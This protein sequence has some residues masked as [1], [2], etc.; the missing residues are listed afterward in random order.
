[1]L[2]LEDRLHTV[3]QEA[4]YCKRSGSQV[5]FAPTII[6][7]LEDLQGMKMQNVRVDAVV[8]DLLV[9]G[10]FDLSALGSPVKTNQ[11]A[12]AG[13]VMLD[14]LSKDY[15]LSDTSVLIYTSKRLV[16]ADRVNIN[17]VNDRASIKVQY[18]EKC[19]GSSRKFFEWYNK[20]MRNQEFSHGV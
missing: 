3:D 8:L 10:A 17:Q 14:L 7:F 2:W 11:G 4:I 16:D 5:V 19:A 13:W 15:Y 9:Y 18:L 12:Y 6:H 20:A 1:M